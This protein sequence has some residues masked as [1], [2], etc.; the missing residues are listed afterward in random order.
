[1]RGGKS[2]NAMINYFNAS[3]R[4]DSNPLILK[5]SIDNRDGKF[6]D[7]FGIMTS[8]V[9]QG[10][11]YPAYYA[12]RIDDYFIKNILLTK[13]GRRKYNKIIVDEAQFFSGDDIETLAGAVVEEMKLSVD[14]YGLKSDINANLFPGTAKLL[15]LAGQNTYELPHDCEV[16]NCGRKA[17]TH[18]RFRDGKPD[19]D[20]SSV[21]IEK[22]N[23]TYLSVCALCWL[24][25]MKGCK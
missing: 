22:G 25:L 16:S 2:T 23:I 11:E 15:V 8:R 18:V 9:F 19:P 13:D 1:M 17:T 5:P 20:R 21:A 14:C 6:V 10:V 4:P 24:E 7:K 3:Q 12:T